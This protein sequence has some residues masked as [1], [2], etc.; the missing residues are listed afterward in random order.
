[1]LKDSED[2]E[3]VLDD[4]KHGDWVPEDTEDEEKVLED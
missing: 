1:M 3:K 4:Y 2:Q